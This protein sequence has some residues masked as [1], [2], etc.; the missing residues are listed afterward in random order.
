[1]DVAAAEPIGTRQ[2]TTGPN[3]GARIPPRTHHT[4]EQQRGL[5]GTK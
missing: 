1:V 2:T 4:A 5:A 3:D